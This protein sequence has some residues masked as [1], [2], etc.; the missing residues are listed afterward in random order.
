[1]KVRKDRKRGEG[2]EKERDR[3]FAKNY[4]LMDW[5]NIKGDPTYKS[6]K[7]KEEKRTTNNV[8]RSHV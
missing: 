4:Q 2:K 5:F 7:I 1:M 6:I 3:K 8:S